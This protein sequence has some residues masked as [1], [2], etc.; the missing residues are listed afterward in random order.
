MYEC[1]CVDM[2]SRIVK[3]FE[4]DFSNLHPNDGNVPER[5]SKSM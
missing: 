2:N 5:N 3:K 1:I 4:L